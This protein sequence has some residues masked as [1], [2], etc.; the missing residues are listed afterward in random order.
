[1]ATD[2][3]DGLFGPTP[4]QLQQQML[5]QQDQS[6]LMTAKL[7][8]WERAAYY[9]GRAG[10]GLVNAVAPA[11]GLVNPMQQQAAQ[12]QGAMQG[13]DLQTPEG[14]R[15]AAKKMLDVGNQ[16]SAYLLGQKAAELEKEQAATAL[17][18]RKQ[19][20]QENEALQLKKDQLAQAAELKK[21]QLEQAA[22]A[23]RLRSE[24]RQASTQQ[25]AD[26]AAEANAT[27]L[28]IAQL[29]AEMKRMGIEAKQSAQGVMTPA[30]AFK[31]KQAEAKSSGQLRGMDNSFENLTSAANKIVN[32]PG[33]DAA[34]GLSSLVWSRPG[35]EASQVE[36]LLSEFK[37]GVKK[38]GLDLVRQGGGIGAMSEKE[39]PIVEGM[40]AEIDPKAGKDA[41][42]SQI[43]KVL[44]KVDQVRQNAYQTHNEGFDAQLAP[45]P[46][47]TPPA[48]P[49]PGKPVA[50]VPAQANGKPPIYATNGKVRIMS[51]DGGVTWVPA[52][53]K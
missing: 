34:T 31:Q 19:T 33:L 21:A 53:A 35:G 14:L 2:T 7:N 28:Q 11:L 46:I 8:P 52:G 39:W 13:A 40:V 38:T 42:V 9:T 23:A 22:E 48:A 41:V 4:D 24:D 36:N 26:A 30:Q 18:E 32:H 49:V 25:R 20:F 17:A 45:K 27:K 3:L 16:K 12:M 51:T 37:S 6:A 43:N 1:M 5:Q 10:S 15:A 44:A 47:S 29:M 50:P